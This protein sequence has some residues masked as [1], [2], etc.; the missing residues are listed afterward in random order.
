MRGKKLALLSPR[1]GTDEIG[2]RKSCFQTVGQQNLNLCTWR[3]LKSRPGYFSSHSRSRMRFTFRSP[4][5]E[6]SPEDLGHISNPTSRQ[7]R[8]T[9]LSGRRLTEAVCQSKSK[10]EQ[11]N[12]AVETEEQQKD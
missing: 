3:A 11:K 12:P 10:E 9:V 6:G 4:P 5:K 8:D 2:F 1:A 7:A